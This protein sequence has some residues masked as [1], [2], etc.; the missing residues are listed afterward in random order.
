M[1]TAS[2]VRPN[3][4]MLALNRVRLDE[5]QVCMRFPLVAE[6]MQLSELWDIDPSHQDA[7][8]HLFDYTGIAF[9]G[10]GWR[11][12]DLYSHLEAQLQRRDTAKAA[13]G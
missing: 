12:E 5:G 9:P 6:Q 8:L 13:G 11:V 4:M 7:L 2:V 10:D 1:I 3:R